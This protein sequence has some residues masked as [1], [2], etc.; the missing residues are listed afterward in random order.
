MGKKESIYLFIDQNDGTVTFSHTKRKVMKFK[1][2][3]T[4]SVQKN[5]IHWT[6]ELLKARRRI[7]CQ[8]II[9]KFMYNIKA[10]EYI[11]SDNATLQT[12]TFAL[13]I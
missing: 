13:Q 6:V 4:F 8:K 3:R 10:G 7:S 1:S 12:I 2:C 9:Y 11:C 5:C